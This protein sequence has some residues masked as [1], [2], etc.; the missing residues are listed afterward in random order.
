MI[1]ETIARLLGTR[2]PWV[3]A[4]AGLSSDIGLVVE[5]TGG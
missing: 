5:T 4:F 1:R 2:R 3:Q